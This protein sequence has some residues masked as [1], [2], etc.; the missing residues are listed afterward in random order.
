MAINEVNKKPYKCP[1]CHI[2]LMF[3]DSDSLAH[4]CIS[5]GGMLLHFEI[6]TISPARAPKGK[7]GVK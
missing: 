2:G 4:V 5:C 1:H 3:Y 6:C 7:W